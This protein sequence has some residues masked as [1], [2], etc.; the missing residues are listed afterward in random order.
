MSENSSAARV[1]I[2]NPECSRIYA[3]AP[4]ILEAL[5]F[6]VVI[7][8]V[9][10]HRIV[11]ANSKIYSMGDYPDGTIVGQTCHSVLCPAEVG[12][13][14]ITDLGQIVDNSERKMVRAD[15]TRVSIIKTVVPMVLEGKQYLIESLVDN[16]ERKR[17]QEQLTDA[18]ESLR[19]EVIKRKKAQ[20]EIQ[21]LAYHDHLTGLANRILFID[22]L[23]HAMSLSGRMAK[24]L[25][26]FF[27]DLDGFKMINDSMGHAV[28]DQLL[29]AVSQR[30]AQT[31]RKSDIVAR[32]GGDEFVIM[33]ENEEDIEAIKVV[34][35]K[36]LNSFNRPFNLDGHDFYVTT[37]IGVA[38]YPTDGEDA[39]TLIKN[40]DIAMYKAKE[41][42]RNQYILCSPVMKTNIIETMK[43][44][45]LLYGAIERNELELYYQP[46][47]NSQTKKIIGLEALLRWKCPEYGMVS[48]AKFIP[49]AEQTGLIISIGEWVLRMA[50]RQNKIWQDAG[51]HKIRMAVNLSVRQFQNPDIIKQVCGILAETG[52]APQYLELEITESIVMK[53]TEHVVE[54]L[55]A[56]KEEG[57]AISIDDFGTEY[58]SLNYLKQ[59]PIDKIK[60][61]MPFVQGIN[62][63]DKDEAITK[64]IIVLA[65]SLGLR[66]IAEGVETETQLSFLSH[67]MCDEIQGYYYHKPMPAHEVEKL[68]RDDLLNG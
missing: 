40:A 60:I 23:N 31:V 14:P 46:Q 55:N 25:A 8:D 32:I 17:M 49:I 2:M 67:R 28:G 1:Y 4:S 7:V 43:L 16:S 42:G 62:V 41:K 26:I 44:S 6:G 33:I 10:T 5:G 21:H 12:K 63:S 57:I 3:F 45:N 48:P 24:I 11:Y 68:L 36:I 37:S 61:A 27:L 35:G 54:T 64:A 50:C 15:G 38:V 66:V 59:L 29:A 52:L 9:E 53:E 30:L 51:L 47:V 20:E 19:M 65:K 18:N 56:F 22:Q 39:D 34:A 58:S 13:C